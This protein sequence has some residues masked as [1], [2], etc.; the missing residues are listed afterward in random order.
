MYGHTRT[1]LHDGVRNRRV[2][3]SSDRFFGTTV[4]TTVFRHT[5]TEMSVIGWHVVQT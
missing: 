1:E 5:R 3:S 2:K 4:N